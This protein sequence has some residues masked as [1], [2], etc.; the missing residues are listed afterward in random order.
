MSFIALLMVVSGSIGFGYG[1]SIIL[2]QRV[3][4]YQRRTGAFLEYEGRAA[5][6][7]GGG[8]AA[9]GIGAFA[10]GAFGFQPM[11]MVFGILCSGFYFVSR[12]IADRVQ[13]PKDFVVPS[14]K[15][16]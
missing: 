7:L 2:K 6:I 3:K 10:L 13:A 4:I 11:V 1:L 12:S 5:Q 15:D 14:Q 8:I 16:V 9:A